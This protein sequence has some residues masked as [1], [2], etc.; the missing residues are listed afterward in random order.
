MRG[1]VVNRKT[2]MVRTAMKRSP[3]R[4]R[5]VRKKRQDP[6]PVVDDGFGEVYLKFVASHPCCMES[7]RGCFGDVVAHH[8]RKGQHYRNDSKTV[9]L[10]YQ[11]HAVEWHQ[12]GC[13][14]PLTRAQTVMVFE[15]R[16][17]QLNQ[18]W[19]QTA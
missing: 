11:H 4:L 8:H 10:C 18:E 3:S 16:I 9:P 13:V 19:S 5:R 1:T 17:E 6:R 7:L 14:R 2:P 12:H 15:A